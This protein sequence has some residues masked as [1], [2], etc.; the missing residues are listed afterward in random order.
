MTVP[1]ISGESLHIVY[2]SCLAPGMDYTVYGDVCRVSRRRNAALGVHGMLLFDGQR[3]CQWL[4]GGPAATA[5]LMRR[6][7]VD[8]RHLAIT[9]HMHAIM[10]SGTHALLWQAGF[11]GSEA[12][13]RFIAEQANKPDQMLPALGR[14]LAVAD[15]EP[16]LPLPFDAKP[17]RRRGA[18]CA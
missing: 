3:F 13:D 5:A 18:A 12:L 17:G 4:Y 16:G 11:V 7:V 15:I 1:L 8:E 10:P 6:I 2:T 14:M 9:T